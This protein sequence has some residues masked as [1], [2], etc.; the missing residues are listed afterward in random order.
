[1]NAVVGDFRS[2]HRPRAERV[3]KGPDDEVV[4]GARAD[5][6]YGDHESEYIYNNCR[7]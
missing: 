2:I 1:M 7:L 3:A 4:L 5:S 6:R